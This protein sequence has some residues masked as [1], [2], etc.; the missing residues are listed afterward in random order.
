MRLCVF[1]YKAFY[2]G[3]SITS[4]TVAPYSYM[5]HHIMYPQVNLKMAN[6][7]SVYIAREQESYSIP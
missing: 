1:L 2:A 3:A 7:L 6:Y 4:I 5:S